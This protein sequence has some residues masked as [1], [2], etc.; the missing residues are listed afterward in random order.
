MIDIYRVL[1]NGSSITRTLIQTIPANNPNEI[2]LLNPTVKNEMGNGDSMDFSLQ[3]GTKY[4]NAFTQMTTYIQ[5]DYDGT[6][7]FYGRVLTIDDGAFGTRKVHCEGAL[8]FLND[9]FFPPK[10]EKIRDSISISD[11]IAEII[12]NHDSQLGND[13]MR[14][15]SI[16]EVPGHYSSGIGSEQRIKNDS[17][18]FGSSSWTESKSMLED[19]KS[20]YGGCFRA[21]YYRNNIFLDWM[22][23]YFRSTV[24]RQTIEVGK[25]LLDIS[26]TTEVNNIFTAVIPIGKSDE[27]GE[28]NKVYISFNGRNYIKVPEIVPYFSDSDLNAGYHTKSDYLSA[29]NN[30]GMIFKTVEIQEGNTPQTLLSKA[31]EWIKDN[32]QGSIESFSVK[33][34]DLRQIGENIEKIL[35]GDQ[36]KIIY[37]I[38]STDTSGHRVERTLTCTA[39]TYDI[40]NPENNQYTFGIPAN[41]L[42]KNYGVKSSSKSTSQKMSSASSSSFNPAPFSLSEP[43]D[44]SE[45]WRKAVFSELKKH[46]VWYKSTGNQ[47]VGPPDRASMPNKQRIWHAHE[48]MDENGK[49]NIELWVPDRP[50]Y[51]EMQIPDREHP[52]EN[53]VKRLRIWSRYTSQDLF[54][55]LKGSWVVGPES[56][57]TIKYLQSHYLF[58]YMLDEHGVDLTTGLSVKMPS[59]YVDE[60]GSITL[61]TLTEMTDP[62]DPEATD[63]LQTMGI[64]G[65]FNP[66]SGGFQFTSPVEFG[67]FDPENGLFNFLSEDG[68]SG[69]VSKLIDG[70]YHYFKVKDDNPNELEEVTNIRDLHI[71]EEKSESFIGTIVEGGYA[72][73]DGHV[74]IYKFGQEIIAGEYEGGEIVVAHVNGDKVLLGSNSTMWNYSV[75]NRINN[76]WVEPFY[77]VYDPNTGARE[78]VYTDKAGVS[79]Y[80]G[81]YDNTPGSSTFGNF[82]LQQTGSSGPHGEP[83]IAITGNGIWDDNTLRL[84]GGLITGNVGTPENPQYVT[85]VKS[86]RLVIGDGST[87]TTVTDSLVQS[88]VLTRDQA[89]NLVPQSLVA[90]SVYVNDINAINGRFDTIETNYLKTNELS[91][92]F[93]TL[94]DVTFNNGGNV[95]VGGTWICSSAFVS[96]TV[97]ASR[98]RFQRNIGGDHEQG[99]VYTAT[100]NDFLMEVKVAKINSYQYKLQ[101]KKLGDSEWV[102]V[103]DSTFNGASLLT[104]SWSGGIFTV[105]NDPDNAAAVAV[106]PG[107]IVTGPLKLEATGDIGRSGNTVSQVVKVQWRDYAAEQARPGM[108]PQYSDTG[109][110]DTVSINA[111]S[112]YTNGKTD[113]Y[114]QAMSDLGVRYRSSDVSW[115]PL[116]LYTSGSPSASG[117]NVS[118]TVKVRFRDYPAEDA[119]PGSGAQYGD[120]T[121]SGTI[122]IAAD[123]VWN[124]GSLA[125]YSEASGKVRVNGNYTISTSHSINPGESCTITVPYYNGNAASPKSSLTH[126]V[127]A[128]QAGGHNTPHYNAIGDLNFLRAPDGTVQKLNMSYTYNGTT[129]NAGKHWWF[130]E[131]SSFGSTYSGNLYTY[132]S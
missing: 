16:G 53:K 17:R 42:S 3:S 6:T 63:L 2:Y 54:N 60:D 19:L 65:L 56:Q 46:K 41:S 120:T 127:T 52:G 117:K 61:T 88:G 36:V 128:A 108:G 43:E 11:H 86:D 10:P 95:T 13:P 45:R 103:P 73:E 96:F 93:S 34:I 126:T 51:R 67:A 55:R 70:V 100:P 116:S 22:N 44:E 39:I 77:Y 87:H 78:K 81:Y 5:V 32:Y 21:R 112:V 18:E 8:S 14:S 57:F 102:D 91:S 101:Y 7:I 30:Y 82:V 24:N 38:G 50:S 68:K 122:T 123:T 92:K 83:I 25:N 69:F 20:H 89:Q 26:S 85:F 40:Y 62:T 109:F 9:S 124:N 15:F 72:D 105:K 27:S 125:G 75:A 4:Y 98:M 47:E 80:R 90:R 94:E 74:A 66:E 131:N 1:R 114:Q 104:G 33:A 28:D 71:R 23:H 111:G 97:P 29:V 115:P 12:S 132:Y 130:Y 31:M 37:V 58:E 99:T 118:Q 129:Y 110:Q 119:R 107:T 64:T 59:T 79:S 76:S 113:G 49:A 106:P 84:K 121:I 48:S 35:V